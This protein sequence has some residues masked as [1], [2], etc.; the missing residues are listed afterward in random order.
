M[1]IPFVHSR[2]YV[3]DEVLP[4]GRKKIGLERVNVKLTPVRIATVKF[5][6]VYYK[7][8]KGPNDRADPSPIYA[9]VRSYL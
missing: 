4:F 7:N 8:N 5:N 9:A 2:R 1:Q 6:T 3:T